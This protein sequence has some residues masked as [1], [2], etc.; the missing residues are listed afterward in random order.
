MLPAKLT[1]PSVFSNKVAEYFQGL[2]G[3]HRPNVQM[4]HLSQ[5]KRNRKSKNGQTV[6]NEPVHVRNKYFGADGLPVLSLRQA[7]LYGIIPYTN[8]EPTDLSST[9]KILI[10]KGVKVIQ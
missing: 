8:Q 6:D 5:P 1:P 4:C 7:E 9:K 3:D 2:S 10:P